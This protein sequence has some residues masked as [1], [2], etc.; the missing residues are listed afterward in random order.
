M[1]F[2]QSLH[3]EKFRTF[4][5]R[6]DTHT[7]MW[8]SESRSFCEH[9]AELTNFPSLSPSFSVGYPHSPT[10]P[11]PSTAATN[12]T[13][14]HAIPQSAAPR[15]DHQ[16]PA[17]TTLPVPLLMAR[18]GDSVAGARRGDDPVVACG[19]VDGSGYYPGA[20]DVNHAKSDISWGH[21]ELF[22]VGMA[23][24]GGRTEDLSATIPWATASPRGVAGGAA[25]AAAASVTCPPPRSTSIHQPLH[26]TAAVTSDSSESDMRHSRPHSRPPLPLPTHP[27]PPPPAP[28]VRSPSSSSAAAAAA[29]AAELSSL[30]SMSFLDGAS[31]ASAG[32]AAAHAGTGSGGVAAGF[33]EIP[34]AGRS[35]ETAACG[36]A[37]GLAEGF[38]TSDFAETF[39]SSLSVPLTGAPSEAPPLPE[40]GYAPDGSGIAGEPEAGTTGEANDMTPSLAS[41]L[42]SST[43]LTTSVQDGGSARDGVSR[44][45]GQAADSWA[46]QQST[47]SVEGGGEASAAAANA[48]AVPTV[49]EIPEVEL[50]PSQ[51]RHR[52]SEPAR[53][54][55]CSADSAGDAYAASARA[56]KPVVAQPIRTLEAV[57]GETD[58]GVG[59]VDHGAPPLDELT[60]LPAEPPRD[61]G[62]LV[63]LCVSRVRASLALSLCTPTQPL[64]T[65]SGS[66]LLRLDLA[67]P[68]SSLHIPAD[69]PDSLCF[70]HHR[71]QQPQR[72]RRASW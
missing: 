55:A 39:L 68:H 59:T 72:R 4:N 21:Q 17:A 57:A 46:Q 25:A 53:L 67:H 16:G 66:S 49:P 60:P 41:Q 9:G 40:R 23:E 6:Q 1:V 44:G 62:G 64:T 27:P 47:A 56:D 29:A 51:R 34:E 32:A 71:I 45:S 19:S 70:G 42:T 50:A 24:S 26:A 33:E 2:A 20:I 36:D 48:E 65:S 7:P 15:S 5:S 31:T 52:A 69:I 43:S 37:T 58:S 13:S 3:E 61:N 38:E 10:L 18:P 30:A 35:S 11:L 12:K 63:Q 22:G 54:R 14:R 8:R 28:A